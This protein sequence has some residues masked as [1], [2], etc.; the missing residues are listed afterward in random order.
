MIKRN[1]IN[2]I[3]K[4]SIISDILK[5]KL[6]PLDHKISILKKLLEKYF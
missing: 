6:F 1:K 2:V 3:L 4:Q 5:E